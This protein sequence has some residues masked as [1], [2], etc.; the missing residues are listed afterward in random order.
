MLNRAISRSREELSKLV[1]A[2]EILESKVEKQENLKVKSDLLKK[3]GSKNTLD[4]TGSL[5]HLQKTIFG[6]LNDVHNQENQIRKSLSDIMQTINHS[7]FSKIDK[8]KEI[9]EAPGPSLRSNFNTA[10]LPYRWW[11]S[12]MPCLPMLERHKHVSGSHESLSESFQVCYFTPKKKKK[13]ISRMS[14]NQNLGYCIWLPHNKTG[15][16]YCF[17][18]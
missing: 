16:V 18:V 12:S 7:E 10:S 4:S 15:E 1:R 11:N 17:R 14:N 3:S 8:I 13:S 9:Q 2:V 5:D 6:L